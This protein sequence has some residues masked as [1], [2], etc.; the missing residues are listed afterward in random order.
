M[1]VQSS[2]AEPVSTPV[3]GVEVLAAPGMRIGV[4][5]PNGAGKSTLLGLLSGRLLAERGTVVRTPPTA[6]VG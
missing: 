5:G 2:P 6:T 4:L 3:D 1:S